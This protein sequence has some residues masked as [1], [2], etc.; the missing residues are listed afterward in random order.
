M[1]KT[2]ELSAGWC[3]PLDLPDL[4]PKEEIPASGVH[5]PWDAKMLPAGDDPGPRD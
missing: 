3:L 5:F 1:F 4:L 2:D